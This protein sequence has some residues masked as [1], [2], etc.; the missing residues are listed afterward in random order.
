MAPYNA[1]TE[2]L[3]RN[4]DAGRGAKPAF[5]DHARALTYAQLQGDTRRLAN[6]LGR[7]G[8]RRE[9]RVVMIVA[10]TV[11][12]PVIFLGAIRAGIVP[13]PLNTLLS[14]E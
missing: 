12:F 7:L 10:D 6:L 2:L 11:E 13:A 14:P 1:C 5:V 3:D 9:E 4:V 8:V